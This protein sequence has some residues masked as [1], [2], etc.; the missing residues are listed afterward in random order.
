MYKL[1]LLV[2]NIF[3]QI[4]FIK[5]FISIKVL[6]VKV[7]DNISTLILINNIIKYLYL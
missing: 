1:F 6:N 7:I 3:I 4:T 2:F 5:K